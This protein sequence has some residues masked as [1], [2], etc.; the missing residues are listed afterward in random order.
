MKKIRAQEP[1]GFREKF[2]RQARD[3]IAPAQEI[4]QNLS[5]EQEALSDLFG[6]GSKIWGLEDSETG[7]NIHHD[8][9]PRQRG[10]DGTAS[11][12]GFGRRR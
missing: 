4:E 6:G 3:V 5:W 12:F 10:D 8:L 2:R 7:V 1:K 11:L 9:N